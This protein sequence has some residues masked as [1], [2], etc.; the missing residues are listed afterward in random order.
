MIDCTPFRMQKFLFL[1]L[2]PHL[3]I[4]CLVLILHG[5]MLCGN[6]YNRYAY[7]TNSVDQIQASFQ[8]NLKEV[9]TRMRAMEKR[10]YNNI[11]FTPLPPR[12][13]YQPTNLTTF[14][15]NRTRSPEFD[16]SRSRNGQINREVKTWRSPSS[17]PSVPAPINS[18]AFKPRSSQNEFYTPRQTKSRVFTP[19]RNS[20][21]PPPFSD[22][23]RSKV[24]SLLNSKKE[25]G[26]YH[27]RNEISP[28]PKRISA[29]DLTTR[30]PRVNLF[31]SSVE[32]I[33]NRELPDVQAAKTAPVSKPAS[34]FNAPGVNA[35]TTLLTTTYPV[36]SL[37]ISYGGDPQGLPNLESLVLASWRGIDGRL[38]SLGSLLNADQNSPIISL[39]MSDFR[40]LSQIILHFLKGNGLEGMVALVDPS[41]VDPL[42]G[43]DLRP[44]GE[45]SI[46]ILIWIARVDDVRLNYT[47]LKPSSRKSKKIEQQLTDLMNRGNV[48]NQPL[49]SSFKQSIKRLAR[50]PSTSAR[51]LLTPSDRPGDIDAIVEVKESK[52]IALSLG[53]SNSG[54]PTTGEWLINGAIQSHELT[55]A[56]DPADFSWV[57]SDTGERFGLS[58]G[59]LIPLIQPGVLDL[60]LRTTYSKYDGTS[61]AVTAFE[62]EGSS[63]SADLALRGA[64]LSWEGKTHTFTY[65]FGLNFERA[66]A[67]NSIFLEQAQVDFIIPRFALSHKF[68]SGVIRSLSSLLFRTNLSSI[69][70]EQQE[71]F[72]GLDVEDQVPSL[73][74]SHASLLNLNELF[75]DGNP[76]F[77]PQDGHTLLFQLT[78]AGSLQSDRMLPSMQSILGGA[79]GVRG[80]PEAC[81]AG[82]RA[83]WLSLEYRWKFFSS[84]AYSLTLSPFLDY[85]QTYLHNELPHEAENTLASWGIGLGI[86]LPG[87]GQARLDFAKPLQEV[88]NGSG[89]IREGTTSD[90]YRVHASTQWE[91]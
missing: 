20:R 57:V 31:S 89:D 70:V 10:L 81:V 14:E 64:P 78:A 90:D 24:Q 63:W 53:A 12:T 34:P 85:G 65:E 11:K 8:K 42:S 76:S 7:K 15:M 61:F 58:A 51:L 5:Q 48:L 87:G 16:H 60:A 3:F 80:Y 45:Y 88:V 22:Y 17:S 13:R 86:N 39:T 32:P 43:K 18:N 38:I 49:Q 82:D 37:K 62:F 36:Q 52:K 35:P 44:K 75:G 50:H 4:S 26:S 74:F 33:S 83:F 6:E 47:S 67:F 23:Y 29:F 19:H 68:E 77:G 91:F 55:H 66:R 41:D 40:E 9:Q 21:S 73:L 27:S 46:D 79:S 69:P 71:L 56:D 30:L 28:Q 2:S 72:G 54:S 84:G 59:Y 1:S 25:Q